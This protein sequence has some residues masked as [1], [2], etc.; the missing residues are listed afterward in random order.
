MRHG[1]TPEMDVVLSS[2]VRLARIMRN[3]FTAT[4]T[5]NGRGNRA[6]ACQAVEDGKIAPMPAD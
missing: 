4:I 6:A 5:P 1:K 3:S 2:R